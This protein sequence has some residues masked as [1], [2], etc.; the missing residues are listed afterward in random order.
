MNRV[1]RVVWNASIGT[2]VAVSELAKSKSKSSAKA[3]GPVLAIIGAITFSADAFS[4]T[5]GAGSVYQNCNLINENPI[6]SGSGTQVTGVAISNTTLSC[7]PTAESIAIGGKATTQAK[8]PDGDTN[9]NP[10]NYNQAVAIGFDSQ[11]TGDQAISLGANTRGT[12]HSSIA[13]GGD[14]IDR[15]IEQNGEDYKALTGDTLI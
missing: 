11:A 2:W 3:V 4:F 15:V 9:S 12:G 1:Y 7:A 10:S 14:D 8:R 6:T 5:G 13:I